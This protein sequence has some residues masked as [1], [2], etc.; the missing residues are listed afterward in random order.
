M[1]YRRISKIKFLYET[2]RSSMHV[3]FE[4]LKKVNETVKEKRESNYGI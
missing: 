1:I 4:V 3:D 2:C